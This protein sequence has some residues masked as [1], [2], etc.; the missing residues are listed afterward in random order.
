MGQ[1]AIFA[2]KTSIHPEQH[3]KVLAHYTNV[4]WS[5]M[6]D[7]K[8]YLYF[9]LCLESGISYQ[10][11]VARLTYLLSRYGHISFFE[12]LSEDQMEKRA[13]YYSYLNETP[14]DIIVAVFNEDVV[15][16]FFSQVDENHKGSFS[17][18]KHYAILGSPS[19]KNPDME[20]DNLHVTADTKTLEVLDQYHA[21]DGISIVLDGADTSSAVTFHLG[22]E[23]SYIA[24]NR[25]LTPIT[26][27]LTTK[28][29]AQLVS[30]TDR[31]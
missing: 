12:V 30:E 16:K 19:L 25:S 13:S 28:D 3:D 4:Q 22:K 18:Q 14:T 1:R 10:E 7:L 17:N 29:Y 20:E 2:I 15:R 5:T 23:Y 9:G 31:A 24:D 11:A 21:Q 6:T 27:D 26:K 8:L